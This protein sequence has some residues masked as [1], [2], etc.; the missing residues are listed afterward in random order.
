VFQRER[1]K[2]G[3]PV[4]LQ[5]WWLPQFYQQRPLQLTPAKKR[6]PKPVAPPLFDGFPD[7]FP[8]VRQRSFFG[9]ARELLWIERTLRRGKVIVIHGFGGMGKTALAHE[10]ADWLTRTGMYRGACFVS[11]EHG[12]DAPMLLHA[13]GGYL[14]I[15]GAGYDHTDIPAALAQLRP[16]L[17]QRPT[18]IIADNLESIMPGGDAPLPSDER[19]KLWDVL[20]ALG[21]NTNP[22]SSALRPSSS[23]LLTT[24]TPTLGDGRLEPG[25]TAAHL[26]LRGLLPDDGYDLAS[27]L[28]DGMQIE[29]AR[30]PYPELRDLLAKLDQHPLAI[31]LVLPALRDHALEQIR[32][33]FAALLPQFEDDYASG[34]NRSLLASLEYSLRRL[35][36]EQRGLLVRLA[37][38]ESGASED[39]LLAITEISEAEWAALRPALEQAALLTP[40]RVHEAIAAPF[41]RF[42]PVLAPYLRGQSGADDPVVEARYVQRYYR[43]ANYLYQEDNRNPRAVRALVWRELP[44]L[45][46]ALHLLVAQGDANALVEMADSIAIFLGFFGLLRERDKIQ[47]LVERVT[48]SK[49]GALTR[50]EYLRESNAGEA[51]YASGNLRSAY[52]RFHVLLERIEAQPAGTPLGQGS[53]EHCMTLAR[54]ARCLSMGGQPAAAES[55]LRAALAIVDALIAQQPDQ[56]VVIRQRGA[57]LTDL[58]RVL[59]DQGNYSAARVAYESGLEAKEKIGDSRGQGVTLSELGMLALMQRDYTDARK[60]YTT[61]LALFQSFGEPASEAV[62]LHQL[63]IVAQEQHAWAVAEDAYRR[64][65]EIKVRLGMLA[66]GNGANTTY[67]QLAMVAQGAGHLVEAEGWYRRAL[68]IDEQFGNQKDV[69]VDLNNLANL[70]RNE[71]RAGNI[72]RLAEARSYAERALATVE[73]L[74][75]SAQPWA[76]LSILADITALEGRADAAREYRRRE[77]ET[78]AA[79]AGNRWQIDQQHG[80]LIA[81]IAAAAQGDAQAQAAVKAALPQLEA[82][83]WRI[84][85]ATRRIWAGEREWGALVEDIDRNSALLVLRV[86]EELGG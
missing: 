78:F 52:A 61:A 75:L 35:S 20:L 13:L 24:R 54:L 33:D 37:P 32:E 4:K 66:G 82:N 56:Q 10:A 45:R 2:P 25:R 8:A 15:A 12:G 53:D 73:T 79:F 7:G 16:A 85:D 86:L 18:L 17:A 71:A 81:A 29:R 76:T 69:A 36:D 70:L 64:S 41:L 38:F 1:D 47:A 49:D 57:L 31:H 55:R 67:N 72:A 60:R 9:R 62:A 63:G 83:G 59:T 21:T 48:S 30:A 68:A 77:R 3:Q 42:H 22:S 27:A 51:E 11:F 6:K 50:A 58:G 43:L 80:E 39:D 26:P 46:R 19:A 28:L 84:A 44:N 74:D 40:E 14:G 34:R 5:D 65:A 23:V